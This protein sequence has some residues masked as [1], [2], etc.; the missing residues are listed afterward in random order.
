MN[1]NLEVINSQKENSKIKTGCFDENQAFI[2]STSTHLKYMF[3]DG[4]T[5]GTFKSIDEPVYV[6]FV[7]AILLIVYSSWRIKPT[8]STDKEIFWP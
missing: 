8:L 3:C 2:Y 4:K 6:S 5:V 1:K 7:I